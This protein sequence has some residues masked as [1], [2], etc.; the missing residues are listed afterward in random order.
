[1]KDLSVTERGPLLVFEFTA[2]AATTDAVPLRRLG[3][4]DLRAGEEP[5]RIQAPEVQPGRVR[6]ETPAR[7]LAGRD[8]VFRV[9]VAGRKGRFSEWSNPVRMRVVEPLET[10]RDVRAEAVAEGVRASWNA[11]PGSSFRVYRRA[12]KEQEP[13]LIGTSG[14]NVFIDTTSEYGVPYEYSVEA[15][16]KT[17]D[18]EA[19]SERSATASVTPV[20]RFAPAVPSGLS[21]TPG[22]AGIQL[23]WNPNPEPDLRGYALHRAAGDGPFERIGDLLPT[24]YYADRSVQGGVRYRY[25][26]SAVDQTGNESE[27]TAPAEASAP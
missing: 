23:T 19:S 5:V 27:R 3:E 10:P 8:V 12:A 22:A 11:P 24:P 2:P 7:E 13:A 21:A 18:S 15:F 17:G 1:V 9:R 20:D 26:V 14:S 25:A 4:V 6:I 16:V